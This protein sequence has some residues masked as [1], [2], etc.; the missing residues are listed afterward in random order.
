MPELQNRKRRPLPDVPP[1]ASPPRVLPA[2]LPAYLTTPLPLPPVSHSGRPCL[3]FALSLLALSHRVKSSDAV[4]ILPTFLHKPS[5]CAI[6][7]VSPSWRL[8]FHF[9]SHTLFLHCP[10]YLTTIFVLNLYIVVSIHVSPLQLPSSA[11]PRSSNVLVSPLSV[12]SFRP[13]IFNSPTQ[14]TFFSCQEKSMIACKPIQRIPISESTIIHTTLYST[15]L[16]ER[17][18]PPRVTPSSRSPFSEYPT[19]NTLS[20]SAL[21]PIR[22][23]VT[24]KYSILCNASRTAVQPSFRRN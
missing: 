5:A 9:R 11:S 15:Q 1:T 2:S 20:L 10:L 24:P 21:A 6:L 4:T 23:H 7:P 17:P 18:T 12:S 19:E 14:L 8:P 3:A 13:R 22:P 16:R